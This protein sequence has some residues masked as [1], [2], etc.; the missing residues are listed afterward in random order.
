MKNVSNPGS[1]RT[2][3]EK[4]AA[5]KIQKAQTEVGVDDVP[6]PIMID[7]TTNTVSVLADTERGK[8]TP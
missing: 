7:L 2:L 3:R 4:K 5:L 1:Q 6:A 8:D